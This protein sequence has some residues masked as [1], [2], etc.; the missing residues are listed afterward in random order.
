MPIKLSPAEIKEFH[1]ARSD[2]KYGGSD[3]FPTM[4]QVRKAMQGEEE[5]RGRLFAMV[6]QMVDEYGGVSYMSDISTDDIRRK[7][8]FLTLASCNINW[9]NDKPLFKFL[10]NRIDMTEQEFDDAWYKLPYDIAFEIIEC[11]ETQNPQWAIYR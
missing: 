6:K 9:E 3:K 7:G 1:L 8:V 4:I 10:N 5:T 11:I 2:D